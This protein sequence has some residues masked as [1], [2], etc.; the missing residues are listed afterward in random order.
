M[1]FRCAVD[2]VVRLYKKAAG[3]LTYVKVFLC[4]MTAEDAVQMSGRRFL[5]VP[6]TVSV[7][8]EKSCGNDADVHNKLPYRLKL[9]QRELDHV[10]CQQADPSDKNIIKSKNRRYSESSLYFYHNLHK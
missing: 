4:K 8:S 6:F 10:Y 9:R 5:E 2:L 3:I 1:S 7:F